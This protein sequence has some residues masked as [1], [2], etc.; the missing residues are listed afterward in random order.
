VVFAAVILGVGAVAAGNRALLLWAVSITAL[1]GSATAW[2]K[3]AWRHVEVEATF[4]P[5]RVFAGEPFVLRVHIANAKRMPLPLVR[6]AVWLPL[7]LVAQPGYGWSTMRGFQRRFALAGRSEVVLDLPVHARRRGEFWLEKVQI[8]LSDPFGL[9]PLPREYRPEAVLLVMPEPRIGIPMEVRR[10]MPFG[11]PANAARLFEERERFAGVRPYEPGDPLNRIHWKLTGHTGGLSTKLFEPTRS[12]D[13]LLAL[14]LAAGEPFW[15]NIYPAIA[16]DVIGWGCYLARQAIGAG[17]R[18]GLVANVHYTRGRGPLRVPAR[19]TKGHEAAL[20]AAM[21][22]M[23]NEATSDLAP[24]LREAGR[25]LGRETSVVVI[26]ARPGH[27]LTIEVADLRRRGVEVVCLSP[28]EAAER[29][30]EPSLEEA[31][32]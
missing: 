1:A 16:E 12:A 8:T 5:A 2:S 32:P 14:D 28:L 30:R 29:L 3:L 7:G 27:W 21:A 11:Q 31:V 20:F 6:A 26:S 10:R 23:P 19:I 22:R 25:P 18:V 15:D 13:V 4:K 24:V 9:V 17:W